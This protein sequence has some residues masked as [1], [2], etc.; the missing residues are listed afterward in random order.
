MYSYNRHNEVNVNLAFLKA[1]FN[2]EMVRANVALAAGTYMNANYAAEPGVLQ[3]ILETNAGIKLSKTTNLWVDAGIFA[4]HIGFESAIGKDCWTLSRSMA[5]ENSPYFDAGVKMGYTSKNEQWFLSVMYLNG[6]QRI[7]R[8]DG[9]STLAF[10]TQVTYKPS[11]KITLNSSTFVGNDKPD[12]AR[13]MRYFHNVYGIFQL[14]EKWATTVGLDMGWE[15][16]RKGSNA[17]NTWIVPQVLIRYMPNTKIALTARA[18]Y[19]SDENGVIIATGTPNGFKTWGFSGNVDLNIS[20]KLMW[21]N[22][23]RTFSSSDK[24]FMKGAKMVS[25]NT[26]ITTAMLIA[27]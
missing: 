13:Q 20:E 16:K 12:S 14:N 23:I 4:S 18:E 27:F 6:W 8:P 17:M 3:N 26:A 10:G 22:E 1:A 21:R 9:N 24:V 19:Y 2:T 15:Q 7:T 5:A 11:E 25:N